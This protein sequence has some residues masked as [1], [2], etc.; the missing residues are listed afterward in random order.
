MNR[1]IVDMKGI[2]FNKDDLRVYLFLAWE[3]EEYKKDPKSFMAV[4]KA[5]LEDEVAIDMDEIGS[6]GI[7]FS[8]ILEFDKIKEF[9]NTKKNIPRIIIELT[10]NIDSDT[11]SG[12]FPGTEIK[13]LENLSLSNF[14]IESR[15][16]YL[17][18]VRDKMVEEQ[19]FEKAAAIRD[20]IEILLL[21][22]K[23]TE[24]EPKQ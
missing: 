22:I 10:D 24:S 5:M 9:L 4:I 13:V 14:K 15:I 12:F 7:L 11:I 23:E 6:H 19:K 1:R 20:E 8:S 16:T 3:S 21:L 18:K 17:N 2:E